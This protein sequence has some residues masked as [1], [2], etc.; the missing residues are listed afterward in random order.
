MKWSKNISPVLRQLSHNRNQ[1]KVFILLINEN[2]ILVVSYFFP[3]SALSIIYLQHASL[4]GMTSFV[5]SPV[6]IIFQLN[7][8]QKDI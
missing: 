1:K 5:F 4:F 8:L 3:F 2:N 7:A 6:N